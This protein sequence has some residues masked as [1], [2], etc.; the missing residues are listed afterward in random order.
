MIFLPDIIADVVDSMRET[1]TF[2]SVVDN[3][4]GTFT[5]NVKNTLKVNEWIVID[6]TQFEVIA[7]DSNSF[8]IEST[9][10]IVSPGSY[11][12]LEPYFLF[13]HRRDI[14]YR[15]T[16]K[17]R[18][19]RFKLQKYPLIALRLPIDQDVATDD[20][21]SVSLNI[22]ILEST[23]KTF[24]SEDRY[25]KVIKP[26]LFPIYKKF[27]AALATNSDISGVGA[28]PHRRVDRLFWGMAEKE[29]NVKYIFDDPLDGIELIDLKVK[30]LDLIC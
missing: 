11:K 17:E 1:A 20:I 7:A 5:I 18:D 9:T 26:I 10:V 14:N 30:I 15:L 29:G 6:G 28:L 23:D 12:S 21:N 13:G 4:D 22:V 16:L 24:T 2:N 8:K 27:L 3:V 25:E 19:L